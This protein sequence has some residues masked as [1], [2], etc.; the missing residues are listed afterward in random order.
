MVNYIEIKYQ[1]IIKG[2]NILNSKQ[3]ILHIT[4]PDSF[5]KAINTTIQ[6]NHQAIL[7]VFQ[8]QQLNLR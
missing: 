3:K 1:P 6:N 4:G 7:N 2:I 8:F 5:T